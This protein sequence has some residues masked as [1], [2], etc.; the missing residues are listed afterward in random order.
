MSSKKALV[1]TTDTGVKEGNTDT[2]KK[3]NVMKEAI[4]HTIEFIF[5]TV[6]KTEKPQA[7]N[8]KVDTSSINKSDKGK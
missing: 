1:A 2:G 3:P 7:S 5:D 4:T 6:N 8:K